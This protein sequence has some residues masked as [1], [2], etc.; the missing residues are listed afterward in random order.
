M[1]HRERRKFVNQ[2]YEALNETGG[3]SADDCVMAFEEITLELKRRKQTAE[4]LAMN[5]VERGGR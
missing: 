3:M 1:P 4:K 2:V 5:V